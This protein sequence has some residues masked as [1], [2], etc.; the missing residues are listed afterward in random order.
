[1]TDGVEY[2]F[3]GDYGGSGGSYKTWKVPTGEYITQIIIRTGSRVDALQ[4]ITN[5]GNTSPYYG[6]NGGSKKTLTVPKDYQIIGIFG[7]SGSRIDKLGFNI[8][9]VVYKD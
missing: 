1:M 8:A 9:K 5:K 6:G 3:T 7:R 2:E 4:F